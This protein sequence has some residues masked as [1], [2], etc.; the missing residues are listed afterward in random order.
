MRFM[1]YF[2]LIPAYNEAKNIKEVIKRFKKYPKFRLIVVDDGSKDSTAEIVKRMN[3]T[4]VKHERNKGKA[5][6]IKTGFDYILNNYPDVS[7]VVLFD[8]DMQFLPEESIKLLKPLESGEAN[9]VTGYRSWVGVPFRHKLGNFVWRTAF[10]LLFGTNFKDTNCGYVAMDKKTV[11]AIR[12]VLYGGYILE[13]AMFT[14][15]IKQG[16][17]IKQVPVKVSYEEKRS[18]PSGVR[19]VIGVSLFIILEGFKY[20]L[21]I[22]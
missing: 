22:K 8:A 7:Y 2:V 14:E 6:A 1:Q 18:V 3:V 15:A 19:V 16:L 4:L 5:E 9:F 13:N 11:R 12:K 10:N 17:K 20:R 21:G